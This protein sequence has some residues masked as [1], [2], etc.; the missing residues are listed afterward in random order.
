MLRS[1]FVFSGCP[2]SPGE[3]ASQECFDK[4]PLLFTSDEMHG[5]TLDEHYPQRAYLAPANNV[6]YTSDVISSKA[7]MEYSFKM[8]LPKDLHGDLV[9]IQW[10]ECDRFP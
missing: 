2:I 9:L 4:H 5:A 8:K 10:C 3:I 7:V 1:S 6:G